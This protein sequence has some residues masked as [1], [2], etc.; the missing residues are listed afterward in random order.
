MTMAT[1]IDGLSSFAIE[2]S[3]LVDTNAAQRL[4]STIRSSTLHFLTTKGF[5]WKCS[6]VNEFWWT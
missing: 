4:S 3:V 6:I 2:V 1:W 5:C